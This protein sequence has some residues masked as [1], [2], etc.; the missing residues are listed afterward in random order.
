M[1]H[2]NGRN[3]FRGSSCCGLKRHCIPSWIEQKEARDAC[4]KGRD[5]RNT[6]SMMREGPSERGI[7]TWLS[8]SYKGES[9]LTMVL[10]LL[11]WHSGVQISFSEGILLHPF[12]LGGKHVKLA[13]RHRTDGHRSSSWEKPVKATRHSSCPQLI[14]VCQH[15]AIYTY[16]FWSYHACHGIGR[17]A[18]EFSAAQR[19][20]VFKN[21]S[22]G[23]APTLLTKPKLMGLW[24]QARGKALIPRPW[25]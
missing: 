6:P 21:P 18:L 24:Q 5:S 2:N 22:E 15:K 17:S 7:Y 1:G 14:N 13:A 4:L 10:T 12:P 20:P 11:Q 3:L 19:E 16:K 23:R 9:W 8:L 25:L